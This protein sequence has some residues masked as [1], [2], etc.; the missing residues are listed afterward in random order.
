MLVRLGEVLYW[1]GCLMA[2][3]LFGTLVYLGFEGNNPT[4]VFLFSAIISLPFFLIGRAALYV[5]AG[6]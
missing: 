1:A 6:R 3:M 4:A 5:L 2:L